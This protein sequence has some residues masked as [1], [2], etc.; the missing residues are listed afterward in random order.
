MSLSRFKS[1]INGLK[2]RIPARHGPQRKPSPSLPYEL[3]CTILEMFIRDPLDWIIYGAE[4][5]PI[6]VDQAHLCL[7]DYRY[8]SHTGLQAMVQ[9]NK[10]ILRSVCPTWRVIVGTL[11]VEGE[12]VLYHYYCNWHELPSI[13][14]SQHDRLYER[15]NVR[16]LHARIRCKYTHPI[17]AFSLILDPSSVDCT[18][19][20][21]TLSDILSFPQYL[22][23]LDF[24]LK[25][26]QT[27]RNLLQD[28]QTMVTSLTTLHLYLTNVDTLRTT[29]QVPTLI[30]LFVSISSYSRSEWSNNPSEYHWIF[31]RLRNLSVNEDCYYLHLEPLPATH[32]FFL[33]PLTN[34]HH[35]IQALRIFPMAKQVLDKDSPLCWIKMPKLRALATDF[36]SFDKTHYVNQVERHISQG[37]T[38]ES[39]HHLIQITASWHHSE[40]VSRGMRNCVYVCNRL[41]SVTLPGPVIRIAP[42]KR[43]FKSTEITRLI[44]LC[45]DRHIELWQQCQ[46]NLL[47]KRW[48]PDSPSP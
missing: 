16:S 48:T 5:S 33:D 31:P 8:N 25:Y 9:R 34:H 36:N 37:L 11:K 10:D 27:P 39:V 43:P 15:Y 28:L 20:L 41:Q 22:K 3:W 35:I 21:S 42:H 17:S 26:C 24:Q 12:W 44:K 40:D 38:S 6:Q 46:D 4:F 29:L 30:T 18:S 47:Q 2:A 45:D 7:T 13:D 23:I 1:V 14:T 19:S 32:P